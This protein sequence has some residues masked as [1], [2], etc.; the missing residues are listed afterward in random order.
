MVLFSTTVLSPS[1]AKAPPVGP[2][3]LPETK[4]EAVK[5]FAWFLLSW[6]LP[7]RSAVLAI[8][9]SPKNESCNG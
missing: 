1:N 5:A 9:V 8:P 2:E 4:I 3:S 7:E 6:P